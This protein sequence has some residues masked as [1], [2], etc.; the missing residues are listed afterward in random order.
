MK[1]VSAAAKIKWRRNSVGMWPHRIDLRYQTRF[2][3]T[4]HWICIWFVRLDQMHRSLGH[5]QWCYQRR[6]SNRLRQD[7]RAGLVRVCWFLVCPFHRFV[8]IAST[9]PKIVRLRVRQLRTHFLF[10]SLIRHFC[11]F[12]RPQSAFRVETSSPVIG[13]SPRDPNWAF[14][15]V[16]SPP[17]PPSALTFRFQNF[18][19]R[20]GTH[21]NFFFFGNKFAQI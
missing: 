21:L 7:K 4:N 13:C 2:K 12:C 20:R 10:H 9:Q 19:N 16:I 3:D 17:T 5:N 11:K 14:S 18:P 6:Q 15:L 8:T 1:Y